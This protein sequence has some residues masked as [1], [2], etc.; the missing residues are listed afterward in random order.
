MQG[1]SR[2]L[3]ANSNVFIVCFRAQTP[4]WATSFPT[5][6]VEN[7]ITLTEDKPSVAVKVMNEEVS[8][9]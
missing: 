9:H 5:G 7:V 2:R 4:A 6:K 8:K 1:Y 3:G